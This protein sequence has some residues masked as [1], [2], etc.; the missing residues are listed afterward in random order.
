MKLFKR[1]YEK[2]KRMMVARESAVALVLI[3]IFIVF[4]ISS[5]KFIKVSNLLNV[6]RQ[7]AYL[8]LMSIGLGLVIITG[9]IDLCIGSTY[10]M[11][12]VIAAMVLVNTGNTVLALCLALS[13][14][15]IVGVMNG[16]LTVK[17]R[18]PS[19]I[20]TF[21]TMNVIRGLVL[22]V[23]KGTPLPLF[24]EGIT[25]ETH[26]G[27]YF[28]GR[29]VVFNNIQVPL[30][31][32][33]FFMIIAGFILR[34]TAFGLHI[35]AVGGNENASYTAGINVGM[36][37]LEAFV[38]SSFL[39]SVAG[40]VNL[41]FIEIVYPTAGQGLEFE[42]FAAVIIGGTSFAG[43]EGSIKGILI[44]VLIMGFIRN[45]LVLLGVGPFVQVLVIGLIAIGAVS[46]DSLT[47]EYRKE[48][49]TEV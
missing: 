47:S 3:T 7:V 21:G 9:N 11:A 22:I 38:I 13:A 40:I 1:A 19:F 35:F 43:G 36:V 28:I 31:I 34:K 44:G 2:I 30:L 26:P 41:S 37:R 33:L 39:S 46:Y 12:A 49:G 20:A 14:G 6:G 5:P 48:M 8:G 45:G 27:F 42:T 29:G 10:G 24:I 16:L 23:T 15:L 17:V 32:M 25:Q 18:L 4:S